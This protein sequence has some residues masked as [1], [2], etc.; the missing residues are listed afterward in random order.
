MSIRVVEAKIAMLMAAGTMCRDAY[1]QAVTGSSLDQA[2]LRQIRLNLDLETEPLHET[3][4]PGK[5]LREGT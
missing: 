3:E 4:R 1:N 2:S 5:W